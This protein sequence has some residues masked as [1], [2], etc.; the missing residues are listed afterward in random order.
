MQGLIIQP[1]MFISR[2]Q[3]KR[4][5]YLLPKP[6]GRL[7]ISHYRALNALAYM[8]SNGCKWRSLPACFGPWH[9]IYMRLHRWADSG[10]LA[11]LLDHLQHDRLSQ[12]CVQELS[13][14]STIV[15]V[16]PDGCGAR[17]KTAHKP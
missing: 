9:T 13:L 12:W 8:A 16:H 15:K 5:R 10:V 2:I 11:Q 7:R 14:D 6:R 4:I 1:C 3:F 17:K